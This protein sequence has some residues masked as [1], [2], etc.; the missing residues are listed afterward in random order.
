MNKLPEYLQFGCGLC[1]PQGWVYFDASLTLRFDRIP[2]VGR[3]YTKNAVRFPANVRYRDIAKGLPVSETYFKGVYGLHVL[4]HLSLQDFDMAL[5][6]VRRYLRDGRVFRLVVPDLKQLVTTYL[7]D[8]RPEAALDFMRNTSLGRQSRLRG[9]GGFL[10]EWL[11]NSAHLWMRDEAAM[12][13]KLREHGFLQIRRSA[14]G[15]CDDAAF[16]A[17]EDMGRFENC[18]AMQPSK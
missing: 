17:V 18:L 8:T 16:A 5:A 13:L 1:A 14:F 10:R 4:E 11:G 2:V 9:S 15:D 3:F 7:A 12:T 6:N